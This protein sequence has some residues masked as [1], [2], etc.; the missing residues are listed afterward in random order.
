MLVLTGV[1][2]TSG[3][4]V[5][6]V[7]RLLPHELEVSQY[8]LEADQVEAEVKRFNQALKRTGQQLDRLISDLE[9]SA[10]AA[11]EFL[12]T[13][14]LLLADPE[15][16]EATITRI[17]E[18]RCNAEWALTEQQDVIEEAFSQVEDAYL[19][20]RIEDVEHVVKM[21]VQILNQD[22]D[23]GFD[24]HL[25]GQL[26]GMIVVTGMISPAEVAI[27]HDRGAAGLIMERGSSYAHSAILARGLGMPAVIGVSR[28][29]SLLQ[30]NEEL[31]LDGHYG[32][33]FVMHDDSMRRHYQT[34]QAERAHRKQQFD[35]LQ[36]QATATNDG[37]PITLM[38]NAERAEDVRQAL[39][40][41][42]QGIGLMR[43][44]HLFIGDRPLNEDEQVNAYQQV[45]EAANGLPV[46]IRT[47]DAGGDKPISGISPTSNVD[48]PA[49][50]LRAVRLCL[51][52]PDLFRTQLRAILRVSALG[53]VRLLIPMISQ[54][55][56]IRL[57]KRLLKQCREN[58]RNEGYELAETL[59]IG[60]MIEVPAAALAIHTL[61]PELDFISIGTNDLAQYTLA[62]DRLD[63]EVGYLHDPLHPGLLRLVQMTIEAANEHNKPVSLCG[64]MAA[65]PRYT[66][67]L[68]GLGLK[69]FSMFA[70]SLPEVK[71]EIL[72]THLKT[73]RKL[74]NQHL[75]K[76]VLEGPQLLHQLAAANTSQNQTA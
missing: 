64:E 61:L 42:A 3:V 39:G 5:G 24:H 4:A 32:V 49:L 57:V 53:Q 44:E 76:P 52:H 17:R 69:E 30:E 68:L 75:R 46:T 62:A 73:S 12:D 25:P 51:H 74:I 58:L 40:F 7:H 54:V 38:V 56:E 43:T 65:D 10:S 33:V 60:A 9:D 50:G 70:A 28:A 47:L 18:E 16:A 14:R 29:L 23:L 27:L 8:H 34:K 71:Q 26:T 45:I 72:R 11:R 41:G 35:L 15:L 20:A 67:V 31:V 1:P 55:S 48:N 13:H 59:P 66:Q 21:I 19:R 63:P 22:G 6:R 36:E 37:H 2:V